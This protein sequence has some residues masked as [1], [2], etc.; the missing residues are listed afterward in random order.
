MRLRGR[1]WAPWRSRAW[2]PSPRGGVS[3][4][5]MSGPVARAVDHALRGHVA[6]FGLVAPKGGLQA[7]ALGREDQRAAGPGPGDWL[8]LCRADRAAHRGGRGARGDE[9]EAALRADA[10]LR[11]LRTI[12]GICL[13]TADERDPLGGQQG[14]QPKPLA[15]PS[16]PSGVQAEGGRGRRAGEQDGP[17]V[18]GGSGETPDGRSA[19]IP[20][21]AVL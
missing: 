1:P 2:R 15:L 19:T 7:K 14:R 11:R 18:L 5:R 17:H 21:P 4:A 13:V 16:P 8:D 10:A 9:L 3:D 6:E 20:R 12:L